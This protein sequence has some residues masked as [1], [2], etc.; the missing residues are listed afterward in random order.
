M[1]PPVIFLGVYTD[2]LDLRYLNSDFA[3]LYHLF[4]KGFNIE[5]YNTRWFDD[6]PSSA[7]PK[8][9]YKV[10]GLIPEEVDVEVSTNLPP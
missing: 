5:S 9:M 8:L 2:T 1:L 6:K 4:T 3:S 7:T 10:N